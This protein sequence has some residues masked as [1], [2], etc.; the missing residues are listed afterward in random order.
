LDYQGAVALGQATTATFGAE[1]EWS[2]IDTASPSAFNPNPP[3]L[4]RDVAITSGYG[5]VQHEVTQDL[6]VTA[7]LRH[8]SH[9]TFGDHDLAEIGGS[10]RMNQDTTILR[11]TFGQGFKAPTLFQLFSSFG[12]SA[13][14]PETANNV[15]AG[16]EQFLFDRRIGLRAT[17]FHR[18]GRDQIDFFS[19]PA[20]SSDSLCAP[21]GV[22]RFGYYA[23]I[24]RTKTDGVETAVTFNLDTSTKLDANYNWMR[25]LNDTPGPNFGKILSRRAEHQINA[26]ISRVW[27]LGLT[28]SLRVRYTGNNFDSIANTYVLK[29]YTLLDMLAS[30]P[31]GRRV[32]LYGRIENL[33]DQRYETT[34]D[35]GVLGRG[36]YVGLRARY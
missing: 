16:V 11:A 26:E 31:L 5:Q 6:T 3:R 15:E 17:Y 25:P 2:S 7:G 4:A 9:D 14:R 29:A 22:A 21:R 27:D 30:V 23:N 33:T 36:A 34:R 13:L 28:T 19:C 10:W 18:D 1:R 20:R 8:D 35:Y 32:E 24:L 12:N